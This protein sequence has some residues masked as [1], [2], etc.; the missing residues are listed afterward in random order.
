MSKALISGLDGDE[1]KVL[2]P[3]EVPL[4]DPIGTSSIHHE[5]EK[6]KFLEFFGAPDDCVLIFC[7]LSFKL[8][9]FS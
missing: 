6:F 9:V 1:A 2:A 3:H 8:L 5:L 4:C 7:P